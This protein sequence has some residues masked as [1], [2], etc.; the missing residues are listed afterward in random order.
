M[1]SITEDTVEQAA[2][3]WLRELGYACCHGPDI[4]PDGHSAER[5]SNSD[6]VLEAR[7]RDA[8]RRLN[9]D[10]N[11]DA[12][13]DAARKVLLVDGPNLLETNRRFHA[14]L[15]NGVEVEYRRPDDTTAGDRLRLADFDD[16]DANDWLAV[17]QF[18]V[19][20]GQHARRPDIVLFLNGLPIAVFELKNAA[21]EAASIRDAFNQLQ[22]YKQQI[23]SLFRFNE[24]LV[25]SDGL[26]ART[27]SLSAN[28]E[29]FKIW[30][31][32][33]GEKEER[34]GA[35]QLEVLIRGMLDRRNVLGLI[36]DFVTFE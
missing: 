33:D 20:E 7:L 26:R 13:D 8:L 19:S 14:M 27:G 21:S 23:P 28:W 17:N 31:T 32:I 10:A 4:A 16:P 12:L 1:T 2:L 3:G 35:V 22:T 36:R 11:S 18:A 9:P 15:A 30:R 24:F 5:A 34:S 25:I 6:V 29:W